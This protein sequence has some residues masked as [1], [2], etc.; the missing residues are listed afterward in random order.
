VELTC[1]IAPPARDA[2]L[3]SRDEGCEDRAMARLPRRGQQRGPGHRLPGLILLYPARPDINPGRRAARRA[4]YA[5]P[6]WTLP[7]TCRVF[8][9]TS[10]PRPVG[11]RALFPPRRGHVHPGDPSGRRSARSSVFPDPLAGDAASP[12]S[13]E[14]RRAPRGA[15]HHARGGPASCRWAH[16]SRASPHGPAAVAGRPRSALCLSRWADVVQH[17][18]HVPTTST[19]CDSAAR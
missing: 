17:P 7:S 16:V 18:N 15:R 9:P 4:A 10:F 14:G 6:W 11:Y 13:R 8:A 1:G 2:F 19:C 5:E 3:R 12:T